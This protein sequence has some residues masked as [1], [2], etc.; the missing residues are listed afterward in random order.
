VPLAWFLT[1]FAEVDE[2]EALEEAVNEI[3]ARL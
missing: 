3:V 2:D 1:T